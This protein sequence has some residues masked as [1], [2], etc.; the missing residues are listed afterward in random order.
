MHHIRIQ[1]HLPS[2]LCGGHGKAYV[3]SKLHFLWHLIRAAQYLITLCVL[4]REA[5]HFH[6]DS[7]VE[8]HCWHFVSVNYSIDLCSWYIWRCAESRDAVIMACLHSPALRR[9]QFF[10]YRSQSHLLAH[11]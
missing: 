3:R 10:F 9:E 5:L 8:Q 7:E 2:G 1:L 4:Y 6:Y 11:A